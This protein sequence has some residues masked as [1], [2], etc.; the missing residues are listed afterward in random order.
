M[1]P[2]V[3]K[4]LFS[5]FFF[6]ACSLMLANNEGYSQKAPA[7]QPLFESNELT[8][9]EIRADFSEILSDREDNPEY[10]DA[11]IIYKNTGGDTI[12]IPAK[13]KVRGNFR[14]D[15]EHCKFPPLL[16]NFKK[17]DVKGTMFESQNK[18]K[19]VTPCQ[20]ENYI[21]LEYMIYQLYNLISEYSFKVHLVKV[22][23]YNTDKNRLYFTRCSFFLEENKL[24]A[25]SN[26]MEVTEKFYNPYQL[27]RVATINLGL[28]EY[29]IGNL[30]WWVTS[31][32]NIVL[33]ARDSIQAPIPVPY[34]FDMSGFVNADYSKPAGVP[35]EMLKERQVYK[36]ICMSQ[37]EKT[38]AFAYFENMKENFNN[39]ILENPVYPKYLKT[40]AVGYLR[41]FY[42]VIENPDR[43][44][45]E[46][47]A[48]GKCTRYEDFVLYKK[49][50][51]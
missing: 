17:D 1:V 16:I 14:R 34:D 13:L 23:Y 40:Q 32:Q 4:N 7:K 38:R 21:L 3:Y 27:N 44:K 39:M 10:H 15:P 31:H 2:I 35:D 41:R 42:N 51:K 11:V 43:I 47:D 22:D 24:M 8:N 49:N 18:L 29:M 28:F 36:G 25:E 30:D 19:L 48:E 46:I 9:I 5:W 6:I 20:N 50:A 37:E 45:K 26:G 12:S 33:I